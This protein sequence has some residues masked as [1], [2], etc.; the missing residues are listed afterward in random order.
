MKT[1]TKITKSNSKVTKSTSK[2]TTSKVLEFPADCSSAIRVA[3][4][5]KN[6]G[7]IKGFEI[8]G[9]NQWVW[10]DTTGTAGKAFVKWY[11]EKMAVELPIFRV[12]FQ[13]SGKR[14]A[15]YSRTKVSLE[16][17]NDAIYWGLILKDGKIIN[18]HASEDIRKQAV[19]RCSGK[20]N[21]WPKAGIKES[22]KENSEKESK[23]LDL[24]DAVK[25]LRK[26]GY[27]IIEG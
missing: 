1:T 3:E 27:K 24:S 12:F 20:N 19:L 22:K 5:L 15:W 14:K 4:H 25:L 8:S 13:Y 26:A 16:I 7:L 23:E 6:L 2:V 17:S 10:L 21:T 18:S 9:P 11:K